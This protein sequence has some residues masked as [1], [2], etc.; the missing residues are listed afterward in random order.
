MGNGVGGARGNA[1]PVGT[2]VPVGANQTIRSSDNACQ[3]DR[4]AVLTGGELQ[5][6]T[7]WTGRYAAFEGVVFFQG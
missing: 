5:V 1:D 7:S 6:G 4:T 3:T 2:V